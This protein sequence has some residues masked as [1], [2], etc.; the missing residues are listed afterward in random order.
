LIVSLFVVAAGTIHLS[1]LALQYISTND[2]SPVARLVVTPEKRHAIDALR[3]EGLLVY[4]L[5]FQL[6]NGWKVVCTDDDSMDDTRLG[7]LARHLKALAPN[8]VYF[9][10]T[11]IGDS[12]VASLSGVASVKFLDLGWTKVGDR[13]LESIA[14]LPALKELY[15]NNTKVS[16][17]GLA[18]LEHLANL[19]LLC[20]GQSEVTEQGIKDFHRKSP[21]VY[22]DNFQ[23]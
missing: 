8:I 1:G 5:R 18:H 21:H 2:L 15:V 17:A 23:R 16:D 19:Q 9:R 12:G 14:T 22:V 3:S 10:R 20:V 6:R 7:R 13:G 11:N 4:Y